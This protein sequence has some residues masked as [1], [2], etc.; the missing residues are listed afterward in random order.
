[1]PSYSRC[2]NMQ[3]QLRLLFVYFLSHI[4]N[5]ILV[6]RNSKQVPLW[7]WR[8]REECG[9]VKCKVRNCFI[10]DR[11]DTR[12]ASRSYYWILRNIQMAS[13]ARIIGECEN[14]LR[15]ARFMYMKTQR[16]KN[17]VRRPRHIQ[18][19]TLI[20]IIPCI[21]VLINSADCSKHNI[22]GVCPCSSMDEPG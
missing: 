1:M 9:I 4:K 14:R 19:T 16:P 10:P 5:Y 11:S 18:P 21:F 22:H 7:S 13:T 17:Y 6:K 20:I 2:W 3:L 15:F 8:R 12:K